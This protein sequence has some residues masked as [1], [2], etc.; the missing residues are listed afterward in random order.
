MTNY[1]A[2]NRQSSKGLTSVS[3]LSPTAVGKQMSSKKVLD[4][5]II[6][7]CYYLI[8]SLPESIPAQV[9]PVDKCGIAAG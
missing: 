2:V 4:K 7:T 9:V 1:Q 3:C 5:L 6:H 8:L